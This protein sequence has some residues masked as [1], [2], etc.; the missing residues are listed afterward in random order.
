MLASA[1]FTA[2]E[3]VSA[4]KRGR[5]VSVRKGANGRRTVCI[6]DRFPFRTREATL[7]GPSY[8]RLMSEVVDTL[9]ALH[10]SKLS[11]DLKTDHY[12]QQWVEVRSGIFR[13]RIS[14]VGISPRHIVRLEMALAHHLPMA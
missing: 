1:E 6:S 11:I 14:R 12:G 9:A 10:S 4:V 5:N 7:D 2:K 13:E 8:D 3:F